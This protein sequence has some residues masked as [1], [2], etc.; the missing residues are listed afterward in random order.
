MTTIRIFPSRLTA[1]KLHK[2]VHTYPVEE[3]QQDDLKFV[4]HVRVVDVEVVVEVSGGKVLANL[5]Q[6]STTSTIHVNS[7]TQN[8]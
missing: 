2:G 4:P 3:G 7:L 8:D 1:F 5:Q 6:H